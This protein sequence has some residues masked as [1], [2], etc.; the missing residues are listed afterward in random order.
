MRSDKGNLHRIPGYCEIDR[1]L[2]ATKFVTVSS[3]K[4]QESDQLW[5]PTG[6][7]HG[8]AGDHPKEPYLMRTPDFRASGQVQFYVYPL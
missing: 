4:Y 2:L 5:F 1:F 8:A 3:P 6:D 7:V